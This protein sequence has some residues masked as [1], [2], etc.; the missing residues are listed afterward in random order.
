VRPLAVEADL[1]GRAMVRLRQERD[2]GRALTE[3]DDYL[4][5]FPQGV[6]RREAN[7]ARAEALLLLGRDRQALVAL[8]G[9]SLDSYGRGVEL[10]LIRGELRASTDCAAAIADFDQVLAAPAADPLAERA[11]YGRA[12]CRARRGENAAAAHD[13]ETYLARFPR[14][15]FA[16]A[17]RQARSP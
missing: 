3:L 16:A 1:L 5:R 11:L 9:V 7:I 4:A 10:R 8:N 12:T 17:A 15:R 6:L 2:G 13:L 14:G